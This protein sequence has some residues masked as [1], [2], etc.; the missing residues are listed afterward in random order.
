MDLPEQGDGLTVDRIDIKKDQIELPGLN[1]CLKFIFI[2]YT[3]QFAP[4]LQGGE[5]AC[6][7]RFDRVEYKNFIHNAGS[8]G[9][10]PF[11]QKTSPKQAENTAQD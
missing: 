8:P 11:M 10:C 5:Y 1:L 3:S 4:L 2:G 7:R 9:D 6:A